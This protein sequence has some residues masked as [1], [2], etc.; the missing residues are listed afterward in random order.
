MRL[1]RT[2]MVRQEFFSRKLVPTSDTIKGQLA[3]MNPFMLP[4]VVFPTKCLCA[5]LAGKRFFPRVRAQ[6]SV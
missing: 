2:K 4:Q 3:G 6:M 5:G 1:A